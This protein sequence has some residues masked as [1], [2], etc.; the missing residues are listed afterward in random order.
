MKLNKEPARIKPLTLEVDEKLKD[1]QR[2]LRDL[3]DMGVI[4]L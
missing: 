1:L 4:Q 2:D 3:L